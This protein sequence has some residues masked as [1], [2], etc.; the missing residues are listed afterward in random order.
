MNRGNSVFLAA[1]AAIGFCEAG[2]ADQ[3]TVTFGPGSSWSANNTDTT[4]YVV[5]ID[6]GNPASTA[7]TLTGPDFSGPTIDS[8]TID[9]GD[10]L[11][12][13]GTG[14]RLA[15]LQ[16]ATVNGALNLAHGTLYVGSN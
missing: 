12:L 2:F 11:T 1:A 9:Q 16:G 15:A 7:I 8:I 4:T 6:G 14:I 3:V 13:T 10:A 5:Q